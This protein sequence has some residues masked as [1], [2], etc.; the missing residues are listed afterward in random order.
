MRNFKKKVKTDYLAATRRIPLRSDNHKV[1]SSKWT[2]LSGHAHNQ[3]HNGATYQ[4]QQCLILKRLPNISL[5][6]DH[7]HRP[8]MTLIAQ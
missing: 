5:H 1:V 6:K 7:E 2:Y 4:Y 3:R 8:I